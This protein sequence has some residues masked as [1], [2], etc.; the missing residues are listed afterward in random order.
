MPTKRSPEAGVTDPRGR[1]VSTPLVTAA[2]VRRTPLHARGQ[3]TFNHILDVTASLLEEIGHE[4]VTTNLIAQAAGV[5]ISTLYGYFSNK[6]AVLLALFDRQNEERGVVTRKLI[7]GVREGE[8]W[9]EAFAAGVDAAVAMRKSQRG[10]LAL[11]LAM[12]SSPELQE[13]D[14]ADSEIIIDE[15]VEELHSIAGLEPTHARVVALCSMEMI[16][17]LLDLWVREG[18]TSDMRLIEEAKRAILAYMAI[19]FEPGSTKASSQA[20]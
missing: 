3:A 1:R 5:N 11:R 2:R 19:Y 9:R 13:H 20:R 12:R 18:K 15:L 10:A 7:G 14:R 16:T 17:S 4:N 8:P 6:Q